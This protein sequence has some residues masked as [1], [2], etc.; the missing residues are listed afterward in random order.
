MATTSK[1]RE[2]VLLVTPHPFSILP[3]TRKSYLESPPKFS[4]KSQEELA[5]Q[6]FQV[7]KAPRFSE[8]KIPSYA[9][10]MAVACAC[11]S[12]PAGI[13]GLPAAAC[14]RDHPAPGQT[15]HISAGSSLCPRPSRPPSPAPRSPQSPRGAVQQRVFLP[16]PR[17]SRAKVRSGTPRLRPSLLPPAG[18]ADRL[19]RTGIPGAGR[20]LLRGGR[21]VPAAQRGSLLPALPP[22]RTVPLPPPLPGPASRQREGRDP[23]AFTFILSGK[24]KKKANLGISLAV[25]EGLKRHR[26][27]PCRH[28]RRDGGAESADTAE[29]VRSQRGQGCGAARRSPAQ[30]ARGWSRASGGAL[31]ATACGAARRGAACAPY[32]GTWSAGWGGR[33]L[34]QR[35]RG[36]GGGAVSPMV[37]AARGA[38]RSGARAAAAAGGC[39]A[40]PRR[41]PASAGHGAVRRVWLFPW[42]FRW[43]QVLS[44]SAPPA[45]GV[46]PAAAPGSAASTWWAGRGWLAGCQGRRHPGGSATA[47][48]VKRPGPGG[49]HRRRAGAAAR[50][51]ECSS[52]GCRRVPRGRPGVAVAVPRLP[53]GVT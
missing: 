41:P 1:E 29:P 52:G 23:G 38:P 6:Y 36:H 48:F 9:S 27:A 19:R 35:L 11:G 4:E 3:E 17:W 21:Q 18:R 22:P 46:I 7:W 14:P 53:A 42:G 16:L 15:T 34:R 26:E 32:H 25:S 40:A 44:L 39:S 30:P 2:T 51:E 43:R 31:P 37:A 13:R 47:E 50:L 10:G 33:E 28:S 5:F 12:F 24:R 45:A 20:H 49:E 8:L